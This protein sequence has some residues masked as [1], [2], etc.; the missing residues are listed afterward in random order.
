MP[1]TNPL[2][3]FVTTWNTRRN[4]VKYFLKGA[5]QLARSLGISPERFTT[6][7][8]SLDEVSARIDPDQYDLF[9]CHVVANWV[10]EPSAFIRKLSSLSSRSDQY[11]S[12][13]IG[14]TL[15][16]EMK[17]ADLGKLDLLKMSVFAS[18]Q[19]L[20]SLTY[21]KD[22]AVRLLD[23]TRIKQ[24]LEKEKFHIV[25]KAAVKVFTEYIPPSLFHEPQTLPLLR[26]IEY[27]RLD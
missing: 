12:L 2:D 18:E 8:G 21:G 5:K 26:E 4:W 20:P 15:G 23:P 9:I 14:T 1:N 11:I 25:A 24:Q 17:Y 19:P 13:V 10:P 3:E 22:L 27:K 6:E 7:V 16:H